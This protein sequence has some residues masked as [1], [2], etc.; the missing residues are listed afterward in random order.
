MLNTCLKTCTLLLNYYPK[1]VIT[2]LEVSRAIPDMDKV[3]LDHI[4]CAQGQYYH[5]NGVKTILELVELYSGKFPVL[6]S[7]LE[8]I[9][10]LFEVTNN[11][12]RNN[13]QLNQFNGFRHSSVGLWQ[14]RLQ[15]SGPQD[16]YRYQKKLPYMHLKMVV[17]N[18]VEL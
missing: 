1:D 8:F 6:V 11:I 3:V 17:S 13:L 7:Y 18:V 14:F 5:S 12:T 2:L 9:L 15:M 10:H 4:Q 16:F